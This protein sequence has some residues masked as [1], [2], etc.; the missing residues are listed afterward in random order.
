MFFSLN[1]SLVFPIFK[2]Q[3]EKLKNT[4]HLLRQLDFSV[5]KKGLGTSIDPIIC[6][7]KKKHQSPMYNSIYPIDHQQVVRMGDE[8]S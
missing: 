6:K 4:F 2:Q 8:G 7:L 5:H 1:K 3:P